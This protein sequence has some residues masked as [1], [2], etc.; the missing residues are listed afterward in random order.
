MRFRAGGHGP[1]A[2]PAA[3]GPAGRTG[4]AAGPGRV[5]RPVRPRPDRSRPPGADRGPG[6]GRLAQPLRPAQGRGPGPA[7]GRRCRP[8]PGPL[9][10][11]Q[12]R[13]RA[14][15]AAAGDRRAASPA[16]QNRPGGWPMSARGMFRP[17]GAAILVLA[18]ASVPARAADDPDVARL[19]ARLSAL[20]AD[21]VPSRRAGLELLEAMP[22]VNALD[23]AR[24]GDRPDALYLAERRLEIAET[25][26]RAGAARAELSRLDL[27]RADLLVEASRREAE[28]ARREAEQL[29]IQAQIHAEETERL[30][31]AAAAEAL[32]RTEAE[33]ALGQAAGRQTAQ[34]SAARRKEAELARQEAELVSGK[35]LPPSSFGNAGEVF[36]VPGSAYAS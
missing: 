1:G 9:G 29:R 34:L 14:H 28:K 5:R 24:R 33:E 31:L 25:M 4:R 36:V 21:P 7:G 15:P 22:A 26:A 19:R 30:R 12:G 32:A 11:G 35:K 20:Q 13:G 27:Q 6:P 23:A 16:W 10:G 3:R 8:G 18:M 2:G 17:L